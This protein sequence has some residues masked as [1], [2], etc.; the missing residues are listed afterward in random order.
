MMIAEVFYPL[1]RIDEQS[2]HIL[3]RLH[4]FFLSLSLSLS[5]ISVYSALY[6]DIVQSPKLK[7]YSTH[8]YTKNKI[9]IKRKYKENLSF[10][11]RSI[12]SLTPLLLFVFD[13]LFDRNRN[14]K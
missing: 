7:R 11:F 14:K 2:S 4:R 8:T 13:Q 5:R 6:I 3:S 9:I 1:H 12:S 10:V